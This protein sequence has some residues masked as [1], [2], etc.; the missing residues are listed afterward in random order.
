[1]A[2]KSFIEFLTFRYRFKNPPLFDSPNDEG[3]TVGSSAT[4]VVPD[5]D[6][7]DEFFF[8]RGNL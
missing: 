4:V 7:W 3:A 2:V 5:K 1:V 8:R 6:D